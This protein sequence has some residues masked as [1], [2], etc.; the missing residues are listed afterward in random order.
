M[1]CA[2]CLGGTEPFPVMIVSVRVRKSGKESAL[3]ENVKILGHDKLI[4]AHKTP[5]DIM[6]DMVDSC[7]ETALYAASLRQ[8]SLSG[9]EKAILRLIALMFAVWRLP[10]SNF[11]LYLM[12]E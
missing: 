3:Q 7:R 12:V 11:T 4:K 6:V 5:R 8:S 2:V 9:I 1:L 10:L